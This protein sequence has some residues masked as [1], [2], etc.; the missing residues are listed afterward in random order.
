LPT[1]IRKAAVERLTEQIAQV[2]VLTHDGESQRWVCNSFGL[3]H[4]TART[5]VQAKTKLQQPARPTP[6]FAV[7][8]HTDS[9]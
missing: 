7:A 2:L 4:D 9:A 3:Q 6:S 1:P 5:I 8:T